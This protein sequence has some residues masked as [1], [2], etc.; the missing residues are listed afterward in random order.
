MPSPTLLLRHIALLQLHQQMRA[1]FCVQGSLTL[2]LPS[3]FLL[4]AESL[5]PHVDDSDVNADERL[6]LC[7]QSQ[8]RALIDHHIGRRDVS[9]YLKSALR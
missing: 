3:H 5:P 4:H 2:F 1:V 9:L 6:H 7:V 8:P